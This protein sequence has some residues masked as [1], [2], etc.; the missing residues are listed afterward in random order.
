MMDTPT[1]DPF[2][3]IDSALNELEKFLEEHHDCAPIL[4]THPPSQRAERITAVNTICER[5][6]TYKAKMDALVNRTVGLGTQLMRRRAMYMS[7]LTPVAAMPP[8]L[9]QDVFSRVTAQDS[10]A[11]RR[12]A[13]VCTEWREVSLQQKSLWTFL[14]VSANRSEEAVPAYLSR[15]SP[16]PFHLQITDGRAL[17]QLS[18]TTVEALRHRLIRLDWYTSQIPTRR[19]CIQKPY[20]ALET[21]NITGGQDCPNCDNNFWEQA[22]IEKTNPGY[23]GGSDTLTALKTLTLEQVHYK[24]PEEL[25]QRLEH[26]TI[27]SSA[28]NGDMCSLIFRNAR[29]LQSFEIR[30]MV[31][32]GESVPDTP[33]GPYT[34]PSLHRLQLHAVSGGLV[35]YIFNGC[36]CPLLSSLTVERVINAGSRPQIFDGVAL[37]T[38]LNRFVSHL[39]SMR[40][41][42]GLTISLR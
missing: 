16:L 32:E 14:S 1:Q 6:D 11:A 13:Q 38:P 22:L 34:I 39:G 36:Q 4:W 37:L 24:I 20:P 26:L 3:A 40:C 27:I 28:V 12:M 29:V 35:Q 18:D 2:I 21:L 23:L 10:D 17:E 9:L 30:N 31:N 19:L 33:A 5:F 42:D 15:S 25:I 41:L 8:E 7:T